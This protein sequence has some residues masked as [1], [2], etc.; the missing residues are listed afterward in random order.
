M[1]RVSVSEFVCV[2]HTVHSLHKRTH[3]HT[4][5]VVPS[6]SQA[7]ASKPELLPNGTTIAHPSEG[8][9]TC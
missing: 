6:P 7:G 3:T 1:S 8:V 5:T 2:E 4:M 9:R